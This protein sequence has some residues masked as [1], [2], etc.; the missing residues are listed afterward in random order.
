MEI[1][2]PWFDYPIINKPAK[3]QSNRGGVVKNALFGEIITPSRIT[4]VPFDVIV[5]TIF[6]NVVYVIGADKV[7]WCVVNNPISQ[8]SQRRTAFRWSGDDIRKFIM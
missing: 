8:T 5:V 2:F 7:T 1:S 4:L 6:F 3:E